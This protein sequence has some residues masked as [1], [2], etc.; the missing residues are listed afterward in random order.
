MTFVLMKVYPTRPC[1]RA[2]RPCE[3]RN[4]RGL[5]LMETII[6]IGILAL[7]TMGGVATYYQ[8]N[9]YAANLRNMSMARALCQERVEQA[10]SLPFRPS[11]GVVP[12]APSVDPVNTANRTILGP[13]TSYNSAGSFTG[14]ANYQTSTETIPVYMQVGGTAA[15]KSANVTYTRVST[16][17]QAPLYSATAS[18]TTTTSLYVVEFTVTVTYSYRS[19]TYTTSMS[20]MRSPD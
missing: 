14:G 3:R 18:Q 17:T 15:A 1:P 8:L 12:S 2:F 7:T 9:R 5:T 13:T 20:T 4:V 16:V 19:R 6:A 10:A 11:A